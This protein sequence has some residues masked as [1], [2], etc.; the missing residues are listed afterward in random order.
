VLF[1]GEITQRGCL[2]WLLEEVEDEDSKDS[3]EELLIT[4]RLRVEDII[5]IGSMSNE[6][7]VA[8]GGSP[9]VC[10]KSRM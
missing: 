6:N 10:L 4:L 1:E 2:W 7:R 8:L 3:V 9:K 5:S